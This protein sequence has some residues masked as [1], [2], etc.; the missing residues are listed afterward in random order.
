MRWSRS[1]VPPDG[2]RFELA[3]RTWVAGPSLGVW[4]RWRVLFEV[5]NELA[6]FVERQL[7]VQPA[8]RDARPGDVGPAGADVAA[9]SGGVANTVIL[10][11]GERGYPEGDRARHSCRYTA[12]SDKRAPPAH[13][14]S[15]PTRLNIDHRHHPVRSVVP[16]GRIVLCSEPTATLRRHATDE[17]A[18]PGDCEGIEERK[19]PRVAASPLKRSR[20]ATMS[21]CWSR[22]K[23][24]DS[25]R[26]KESRPRTG[27]PSRSDHRGAAPA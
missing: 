26:P 17:F 21:R 25:C 3:C 15:A 14:P 6:G 5:G 24:A 22:R 7:E 12:A 27:S 2:I 23:G 9:V 18:S 8:V 1:R 19:Q 10:P 4:L 11:K 20:A 13:Q 16:P